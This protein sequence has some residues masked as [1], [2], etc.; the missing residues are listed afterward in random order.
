MALSS[1]T[2][3]A[4]QGIRPP[5]IPRA[6]K[7][8]QVTGDPSA[9]GGKWECHN[10]PVIPKL[11]ILGGLHCLMTI[12]HDSLPSYQCFKE[13]MDTTDPIPSLQSLLDEVSILKSK[14]DV[15]WLKQ[16]TVVD[17][18]RTC[19][20]QHLVHFSKLNKDQLQR[21]LLCELIRHYRLR[22]I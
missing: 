15:N 22:Q 16:A 2:R 6:S 14:P 10:E 7:L 21:L 12:F 8:C 20:E 13:K 17:L 9:P 3:A 18:K 19:K 11:T 1:T 5:E 4:G